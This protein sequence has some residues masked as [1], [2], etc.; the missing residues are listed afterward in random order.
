MKI[1]INCKPALRRD[2]VNGTHSGGV[3]DVSGVLTQVAW[4]TVG[5]RTDR[6]VWRGMGVAGAV[7]GGRAVQENIL[8]RENSFIESGRADTWSE[9]DSGG[10]GQGPG[11]VMGP[12][13]ILSPRLVLSAVLLFSQGP[14]FLFGL[15]SARSSSPSDLSWS[16]EYITKVLETMVLDTSN[17]PLGLCLTETPNSRRITLIAS[18]FISRARPSQTKVDLLS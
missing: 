5:P 3:E 18:L 13:V 15:E 8:D 4:K 7:G 17:P 9:Y 14:V 6:Q 10:A 1:D 2:H 12:V 16:L 11:T